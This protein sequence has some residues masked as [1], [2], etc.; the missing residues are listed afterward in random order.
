[1]LAAAIR[2]SPVMRRGKRVGARRTSQRCPGAAKAKAGWIGRDL[3]LHCVG[4]ECC[5]DLNPRHG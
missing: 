4:S 1:M 2:T 5:L 3:N